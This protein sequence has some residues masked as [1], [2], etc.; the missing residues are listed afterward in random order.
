MSAVFLFTEN[1]ISSLFPRRYRI[2]LLQCF[3]LK[4]DN[5][6]RTKAEKG[7]LTINVFFAYRNIFMFF[8]VSYF[9]LSISQTSI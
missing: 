6:S 5:I 7:L 3:Y 1:E 4:I 9:C 8:Q 2:C